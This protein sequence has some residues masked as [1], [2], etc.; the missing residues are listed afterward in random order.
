MSKKRTAVTYMPVDKDKLIRCLTEH[1]VSM[2]AASL[3]MGWSGAYIST[4][5]NQRGGLN[6]ATIKSLNLIYGIEYDEYKPDKKPKDALAIAAPQK[7]DD[8]KQLQLDM[9]T[10]RQE[11]YVI[12]Q[13]IQNLSKVVKEIYETLER[14]YNN[15][16][17]TRDSLNRA[18]QSL[19]EM[20]EKIKTFGNVKSTITET[21]CRTKEILNRMKNT[22]K[23]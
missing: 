12:N 8:F 9:Q 3:E 7:S 14:T 22:Q 2:E 23:Q 18:W 19:S 20:D 13:N 5:V 1:G 4:L 6:K 15:S 10:L 16:V 17:E 21:S 11:N